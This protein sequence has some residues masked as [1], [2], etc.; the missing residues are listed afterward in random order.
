VGTVVH[1]ALESLRGLTAREALEKKAISGEEWKQL[2]QGADVDYARLKDRFTAENSTPISS[3][4]GLEARC[5]T[6]IHD[7]PQGDLYM[8]RTSVSEFTV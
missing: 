2:K 4:L 6:S 1:Y 8:F 3:Q 7:P 5:I